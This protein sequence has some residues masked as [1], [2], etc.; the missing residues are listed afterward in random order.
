MDFRKK[1]F[2]TLNL[3]YEWYTSRLRGDQDPE[4]A[5]R[6]RADLL[7]QEIKDKIADQNWFEFEHVRGYFPNVGWD[8]SHSWVE[9]NLQYKDKQGEHHEVRVK[10]DPYYNKIIFMDPDE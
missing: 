4:L 2:D 10:Y 6:A 7:L 9:L 8:I 1:D 5:C 3:L